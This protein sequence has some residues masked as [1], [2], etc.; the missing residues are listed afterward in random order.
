MFFL[1]ILMRL[2]LRYIV[3]LF[4][5]WKDKI[6]NISLTIQAQKWLK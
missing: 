1:F 2:D 4:W 6:K 3:K 5:N